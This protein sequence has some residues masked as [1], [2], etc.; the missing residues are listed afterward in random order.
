MMHPIAKAFF[1]PRGLIQN[2][3]PT[4]SFTMKTNHQPSADF[5]DILF[6]HRNK[7][8]GAYALRRQYPAH[9]LKALFLGLSLAGALIFFM[10]FNR[11]SELLSVP[12]ISVADTLKVVAINPSEE[13]LPPVEPPP[14][15]P[16]TSQNSIR[17]IVPLIVPDDTP[18]EDSVPTVADR[19]QNAI[20]R[21]NITVDGPEE[22]IITGIDHAVLSVQPSPAAETPEIYDFHS[23]QE[24]ASFPGGNKALTRFME[25]NLR[26]PRNGEGQAGETIRVQ[27]KFVVGKDGQ[28]DGFTVLGSGGEL[29]DK[30]VLRVLRK[31]PRWKPARQH[32]Q[33]VA[34]FFIMPVSFAS[35][36]DE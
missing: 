8:Y 36:G 15:G 4:K 2:F 31:M 22:E 16:P 10:S 13:I 17:D 25:S 3:S 5:L 34:M 29:F 12:F 9:L 19:S 7:A 18:I 27:V 11:G 30:E 28:P 14:A 32:N 20:G 6:E 26:D 35:I 33:Q 1:I 21:N 24:P 23:V